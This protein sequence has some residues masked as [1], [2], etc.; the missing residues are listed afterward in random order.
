MPLMTGLYSKREML[1][2]L[3]SALKG[4][5]S[6]LKSS[7]MTTPPASPTLSMEVLS[8]GWIFDTRLALF[9]LALNLTQFWDRLQ[10]QLSRLVRNVRRGERIGPP[11]S[12]LVPDKEHWEYQW[13]VMKQN[14]EAF[15]LW[16]KRTKGRLNNG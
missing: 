7:L 2:T 13:K 4:G 16:L 6:R 14:L 8:T 3:L 1:S 5:L 10:L 15:G 12:E 11:P 9:L